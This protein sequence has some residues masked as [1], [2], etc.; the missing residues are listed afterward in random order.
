[1]LCGLLA[2]LNLYRR[3]R[4]LPVNPFVQGFLNTYLHKVN[5]WGESAVP[6]LW[7]AALESE[8]YGNHGDAEGLILLVLSSIVTVNGD[9]ETRDRALPNPYYGPDESIRLANGLDPTNRET[10]DKHSYTAE[11][12]IDFLARRL[13]RQNLASLWGKITR[14]QFTNF[15]VRDKWEW[16]RWRAQH[17][18]LKTT[19]P[20]M[21]ESWQKLLDHATTPA[22]GLPRLIYSKPDYALLFSLVF[23]HRFSCNLAKLVEESLGAGCA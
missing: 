19:M 23:P 5:L 12:L 14:I 17:G 11:P 4:K 6:Y 8:Q 2:G 10:F 21:P 20:G 7:A 3:L 16:F 13:V 9:R 15:S 18:S 22:E 1:M